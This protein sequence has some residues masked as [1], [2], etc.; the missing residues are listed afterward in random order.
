MKNAL[1]EQR[2]SNEKRNQIFNSN[3][4]ILSNNFKKKIL[5]LLKENNFGLTIADI[6]KELGTTRHTVSIILAELRGAEII[7]IRKVGVAKIHVLKL[8][9][10]GI[11]R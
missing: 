11:K 1:M 6:S 10:R 5:G 2:N 3:S 8:L 9:Q 7:E 4:I